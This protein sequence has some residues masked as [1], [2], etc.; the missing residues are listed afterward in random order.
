MIFATERDIIGERRMLM[1]ILSIG[2]SFSQDS[3]YYLHQT[4]AAVGVDIEVVNLYIG[5]CTLERHYQNQETNEAAYLYEKNGQSNERYV[6]LQEAL[7]E[8]PWDVVSFQQ[9]SGN[10]GWIDSYEPFLGLLIAYVKERAPQAKLYL[11]KTWA[12]DDGSELAQFMRYHRSQ[13]EMHAR[14]TAAYDTYS[15]KYG[16]PIIPIGDVVHALRKTGTFTPYV[17]ENSISRDSFHLHYLYGRYAAALTWLKTLTGT[18]ATDNTYVPQTP[19]TEEKI[20]PKKLQL[21]RETV[22]CIL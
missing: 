14:I 7:D 15:Q 18:D 20:D 2:N 16:L 5:G 19:F 3:A 8:E 6:S 21:V 13:E 17:G 10:S 4:A 12:Y 1:K 22:D 9:Q 11:L